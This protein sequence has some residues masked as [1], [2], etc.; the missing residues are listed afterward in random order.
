MRLTPFVVVVTGILTMKPASAAETPDEPLTWQQPPA[1]IAELL[2]APAT[3]VGLIAPGGATLALLERPRR[4]SI[5]EL[6][7]PELRLAGLRFDPRNHAPAL[8]DTDV[9]YKL[10]DRPAPGSPEPDQRLEGPFANLHFID[11]ETG[12]TRTVSGLPADARISLPSWSPDGARLALAVRFA[13]RVEAWV[14]DVAT[15]VARPIGGA[16]LNAIAGA[17]FA[18]LPDSTR[19]VAL[20]VSPGPAPPLVAGPPNG[21]LV[22][23]HKG[24]EAPARTYRD[25][26]ASPHDAALFEHF[27][28]ARLQIISVFGKSRTV[29]ERAMILSARPS[30]DGRYL[31]MTI[32]ERPFS[33]LVPVDRFARRFE[34]WDVE[35]RLLARVGA[36]PVAEDVPV[37]RDSVPR[38]ERIVGWRSDAPAELYFV[39]AVDGGDAGRSADSRDEVLLLTAPFDNE[40]RMLAILSQRFEGV[41]WGNDALALIWESWWS[42]RKRRVWQVAPGGSAGARR[43]I[44][45]FS[46]QDLQGNPGEPVERTNPA[47]HRVLLLVD[48]GRALYLNGYGASTEGERPFLDRLDLATLERERVWESEPPHFEKIVA[49]LDGSAVRVVTLRESVEEPPDFFRRDLGSGQL[50]ALTTL[51]HPYPALRGVRK[52]LLRYKRADGVTLSAYLYLPAG[53][54]EGGAALPTLMW[55]YPLEYKNAEDADQVG[56]SA[57]RFPTVRLRSV[58]PWVTQGYAVL[59]EVSM[60]ILGVGDAEPNDSFVEQLVANARAAIEAGVKRGVVDR[61]RVAILGHSYGAFMATNLLVYSDLFRTAV[62]RSGAYNRTLTPFGFQREERTLWEAP[63]VYLRLSPF[64]NAARIEEPLLLIHGTDDENEGTHPMQSERLYA[65]LKGLGKTTRLVLLPHEGHS[66]FARESV[67]HQAWEINRWLQIHLAPAASDR[68]L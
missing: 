61:D 20:T 59:D 42:T 1:P 47:G 21:P 26:L 56:E 44:A 28:N 46:I 13:D 38:G 65:A 43:L 4:P 57:Y 16:P 54:E 18:W 68:S 67:L 66:Y 34:V 51:P 27:I 37:G 22:R 58:L 9:A 11:L 50:L 64:M 10:T 45:E 52:E 31:L 14:A 48:D 24:G 19:L 5:A 33:W 2:D 3:P 8:R 6:A 17:P 29:G 7:G 60:P 41:Q 53:Y 40:P 15:A 62:A 55:A 36:M 23:D 30:P 32:L 49:L 12:R 25:L 39:R 35:G 63:E